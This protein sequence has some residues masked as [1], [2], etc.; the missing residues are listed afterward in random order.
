MRVQERG[1]SGGRLPW[2]SASGAFEATSPAAPGVVLSVL[3]ET[4]EPERRA[5]RRGGGPAGRGTAAHDAGRGRRRPVAA[6]VPRRESPM[7]AAAPRG[8]A[9]GSVTFEDVAV[10]FSWEEWDLL[11]EAQRH[12]YLDVMLENLALTSSLGGLRG[13]E[14]EAVPSEPS[15][16]VGLPGVMTLREDLLSQ[17]ACPCEMCGLVLSNTLQ[18][19][20]HH[21]THHRQKPGTRGRQFHFTADLLEHQRQHIKEASFGGDV[22]R[23]SFIKSC[24]T[25][26]SGKPFTCKEVGKGFLPSTGFPRHQATRTGE[27]PNTSDRCGA[28]FHGGKRHHPW[29][30]C[31]K[32]AGHTDALVQDQRGLRREGL[33]ECSK[34]GKACTRRCNLVQHQKVHSEDRPFQ[35]SAC[36]KL[37]AYCSSFT[38][39]Q[40]VHTGERP[41]E[42]GQCGK[43]FSQVYSLNSHRKVHTGERPHE[44]GECGKFF[45]QRS[46]LI[47]HQRVHTGERPY[48][49]RECGKAFSQNFS[50]IYHQR[51]HTGERPHEC[52]E[53]GKAFSR[54]SS[55]IH[56]RRLHTGERPYECRECGKSFKQSSSFSS[57]RK[58]H[59]GE[60]PYVCEECGKSFS[61]SSNLKNHQ[62]VH[63]GERPIEC[64]E[65]GKSF[66]CKSNLIK[67]L[68]VHTGERPYEC[69]ECGKAFSQSSSLIQHQRIHT[70]KRPYQCTECGKSFGCKSVLIQHQRVH[71]GE[72]S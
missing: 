60:R 53:C 50:L 28:T 25:H 69:S 48:E 5:R 67:H 7:E 63:T 11:D 72:G 65:C 68:R 14:R 34:C 61:H 54:S 51:V 41:Y 66:S 58:V 49:C 22:D 10:Y 36:G 9:G 52:G 26:E 21:R 56:H 35:C 70:G 18:L 33:F 17:N 40:R 23:S 43:A 4:L 1:A 62:R 71:T 13:V 57:H 24:M 30:D 44:C 45:S 64:R 15:V 16:S 6:R 31:K 47:Q 46:N 20:Q 42:C 3:C 29:G 38:I 32:A 59:T 2:G 55:L 37:F 27:K 39:H 12:L 19:A 8:P